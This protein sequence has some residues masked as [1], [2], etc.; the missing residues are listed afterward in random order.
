MI[1]TELI[2]DRV[3]V[4]HKYSFYNDR[5]FARCVAAFLVEY[6]SPDSNFKMIDSFE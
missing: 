2:F 5:T 1:G 3:I 4:E 6:E